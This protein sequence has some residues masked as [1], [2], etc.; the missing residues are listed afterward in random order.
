MY[1]I[2]MPRIGAPVANSDIPEV[3]VAAMENTMQQR[4][5][6]PESAESR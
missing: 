1:T 3:N 5:D 2:R 4:L 6:A